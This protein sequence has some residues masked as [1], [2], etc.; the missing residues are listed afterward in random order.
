MYALPTHS[1]T[2]GQYKTKRNAKER[3]EIKIEKI[4]I[5][6]KFLIFLTSSCVVREDTLFDIYF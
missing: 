4:S 1:K 3:Y 5:V 2:K 6:E